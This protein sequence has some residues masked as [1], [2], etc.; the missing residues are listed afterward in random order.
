[1]MNRRAINIQVKHHVQ[2]SI[3]KEEFSLNQEEGPR[4]T[5]L[6]EMRNYRGPKKLSAKQASLL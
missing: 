5:T 6:T 3:E 1:M 4:Y 2:S